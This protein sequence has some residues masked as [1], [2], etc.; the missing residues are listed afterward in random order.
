MTGGRVGTLLFAITWPP[1]LILA[2]NDALQEAKL[3]AVP[4]IIYLPGNLS[5]SEEIVL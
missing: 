3:S 2:P 4:L 1:C 5:S